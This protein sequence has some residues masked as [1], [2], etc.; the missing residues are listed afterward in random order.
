MPIR[1]NPHGAASPHLLLFLACCLLSLQATQCTPGMEAADKRVLKQLSDSIPYDLTAPSR[2]INL[3]SESLQEISGLSPTQEPGVFLAI[4][5]EKGEIFF[6][7]GNGGGAIYTRVQFRD[8]GD[9]E[10]VEK[11]DKKMY[12]IKSDGDLYEISKWKNGNPEVKVFDTPLNKT[13][14]VEGLGYD[15]MRKSLLVACKGNP[16]SDSLRG[17]FAF[18][19][20]KNEM[21]PKPVYVIDPKEINRLLPYDGD[22]KGG[23]F[24]SPSGVAVHPKTHDIY[25]ISTALKRL[26]ILDHDTG[27]IR[28]A[29]R[30]DKRI[31]PQPEGIAFDAEG[32][33]FLSSEGKKGE[34][35]LLRFDLR[36]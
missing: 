26:A 31:L 14:D 7:D 9:F 15:P 35:M 19:I 30:L 2:I 25:V 16:E 27:K 17:I 10:G 4:A 34:G 32:N 6:I 18:S 21:D 11:V 5:D 12:A 13:D 29:V 1:V 8:R 36:K 3:A 23:R 20:E 24:F 22:D 33:L 28:H